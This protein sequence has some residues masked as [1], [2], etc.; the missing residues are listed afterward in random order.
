M[1]DS[2]TSKIVCVD[3][4]ECSV[5]YAHIYA[6]EDF[7]GIWLMDVE[8][9]KLTHVCTETDPDLPFTDGQRLVREKYVDVLAEAGVVQ[10]TGEVYDTERHGRLHRCDVPV[11]ERVPFWELEQKPSV[12]S[13]GDQPETIE[14]DTPERHRDHDSG[15]L[16]SLFGRTEPVKSETGLTEN[17]YIL[18]TEK[19]PRVH[20][21]G[22]DCQVISA[23]FDIGHFPDVWLTEC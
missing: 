9:E 8:T 22:R 15:L 10:P 18:A 5:V 2:D 20:F 11:R 16:D 21:E 4:R 14:H 23:C 17:P 3:G 6:D 19:S 1:S 7:Y 12:V 13:A